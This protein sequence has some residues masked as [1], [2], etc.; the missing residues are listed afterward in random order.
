VPEAAVAPVWFERPYNL[1]PAGKSPEYLAQARVLAEKKLL[2]IAHWV[3]RKHSY[4]GALRSNGEHLTLCTLHDQEEVVSAP[5]VAAAT[6]AADAR[7]LA[8]AEQLVEALAGEFDPHEFKDEHSARV[9][10][11]IAA[12]AKGKTVKM[13]RR[14]R[15]RAPQPLG[16]ALEQS[17]KLVQG[18]R[19]RTQRKPEPERLSA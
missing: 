19:A 14:E 9:R 6:R 15:Q 4:V 17:L 1:G 3:M 13:P 8:M 11:L 18:K 16:S 12:K 5:Q 2:G 7:E 10:E